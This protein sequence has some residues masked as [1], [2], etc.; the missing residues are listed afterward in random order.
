MAK[1]EQPSWKRHLG[2]EELLQGRVGFRQEGASLRKIVEAEDAA[3]PASE[4]RDPEKPVDAVDIQ[5]QLLEQ[6]ERADASGVAD[7]ADRRPKG[8]LRLLRRSTREPTMG[9]D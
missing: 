4:Q 5:P 3:I 1:A 8:S 9:V 7:V 2:R 6:G